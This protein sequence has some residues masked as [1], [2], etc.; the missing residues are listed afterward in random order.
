[1]DSGVDFQ[2]VLASSNDPRWREKIQGKLL[3]M[4]LKRLD[5]FIILTTHDTVSSVKFRELMLEISKPI[6]L[7]GDEVHGMGSANRMKGLLS[8]YEY[9]LGLSATPN[10]YFDDTGTQELFNYCN[11][12]GV[13]FLVLNYAGIKGWP[14]IA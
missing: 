3:D 4:R 12:L 6:I 8:N 7:I 9:R 13:E 10:R 11:C 14:V 1:L 2:K 5:K